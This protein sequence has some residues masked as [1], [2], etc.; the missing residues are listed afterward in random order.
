MIIVIL[1]GYLNHFVVPI[2][3]RAFYAGYIDFDN[4]ERL[5]Q[6]FDE[7]KC[8]LRTNGHGWAKP[9]KEFSKNLNYFLLTD[10]A[11]QILPY[12]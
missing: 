12:S 6:L 7:I 10:I 1:G 9:V 8:F 2:A 4:M 3:K 5:Y 11:G